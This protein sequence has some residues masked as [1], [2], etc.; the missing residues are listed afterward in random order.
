MA[1]VAPSWAASVTRNARRVPSGDHRGGNSAGLCA[2]RK[3][4][5][6][7]V[8]SAAMISTRDCRSDPL[9]AVLSTRV[10]RDG[11]PPVGPPAVR[12]YDETNAMRRPSGDHVGKFPR[13][14]AGDSALVRPHHRESHRG[15]RQCR[16]PR[17]RPDRSRGTPP[18]P[19]TCPV[20]CIVRPHGPNRSHTPAHRPRW[21]R[22]TTRYPSGRTAT[23]HQ[24]RKTAVSSRTGRHSWGPVRRHRIYGVPVGK[25]DLPAI[26]R[27]GSGRDQPSDKPASP[28]VADQ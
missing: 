23:G 5:R 10:R 26:T 18:A 15:R 20:R 17:R 19:A 13:D 27:A 4:L 2:A 22:R 28:A 14:E 21:K 16:S 7:P 8:P 6:N 9:G 24:H 25:D 3:T 1:C 11:A 12:Q